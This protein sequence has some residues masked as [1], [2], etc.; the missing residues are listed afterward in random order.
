MGRDLA[1]DCGC[2][3]PWICKRMACCSTRHVSRA[4][5]KSRWAGFAP[6]LASVA[7]KHF[8]LGPYVGAETAGRRCYCSLLLQSS[9]S[10]GPFPDSFCAVF[11]LRELEASHAFISDRFLSET[12]F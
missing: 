2:T 9:P 1:F 6:L 7:C 12:V 11:S 3:W 4:S 10:S 8:P 5:R